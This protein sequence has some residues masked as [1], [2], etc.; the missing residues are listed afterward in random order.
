MAPD[1]SWLTLLKSAMSTISPDISTRRKK[2]NQLNILAFEVSTLMSKLLSLWRSLSDSRLSQLRHS[3]SSPGVRKVVSDDDSFLLALIFAE[4]TDSLRLISISISHLS[5]RCSDP[6]LRSFACAFKAFVSS[7]E[8]PHH[9]VMSPKDMHSKSK[10]MDRLISATSDL[11]KDLDD[12][13]E[14]EQLLKKVLHCSNEFSVNKLGSIADAQQ[15]VFRHRQQVEHLKQVSLWGC[16]FDAAVALLATS[17]FTVLARI[18]HAFGA[19]HAAPPRSLS[20][21][22]YPTPPG[23]MI[24]DTTDVFEWSRRM[25]TAPDTTL[26]AAALAARYANVV[27]AVEKTMRGPGL[28]GTEDRDELYGMLPDGVKGLVRRRLRGVVGPAADAELA[29]EWREAMA[30][31]MAWLGPLAHDTVR[32]QSEGWTLERRRS[33]VAGE[34][35]PVVMMWQT[36][37][38]ANREKVEAAVTELLVGL[39]YICRFELEL[40]SRNRVRE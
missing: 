29:M 4:L 1:H 23:P 24:S 20:A 14:A 21:A 15:R 31:I 17:C 6:A 33:H 19:G 9:W 8:D 38:F 39:N 40:R 5:S 18:R 28:V 32:W 30:R 22:V 10:K 25:L 12:L 27:I 7:G 2:G 34:V 35:G 26:G 36:L 37:W 11:H 3:I 16:T 13:A